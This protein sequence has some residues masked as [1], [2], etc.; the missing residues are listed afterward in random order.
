MH[1]KSNLKIYLLV[2]RFGESIDFQIRHKMENTYNHIRNLPVFLPLLVRQ[3]GLD[4]QG[5]H[6]VTGCLFVLTHVGP[7]N[8]VP[9]SLLLPFSAPIDKL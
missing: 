2:Q 8:F 7:L 9:L 1:R 5:K 3:T 4:G 6:R